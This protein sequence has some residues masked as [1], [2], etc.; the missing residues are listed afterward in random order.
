MDRL[1]RAQAAGGKALRRDV[2]RPGADPLLRRDEPEEEKLLASIARPI[3]LLAKRQPVALAEAVAPRNRYVGV[4]LPYTPLHH[5]LLRHGFRPL[6]MTSGNLSEEPIAIDNDDAFERL[7]GIADFFLIHNR[8]IYLRSDDSVVRRAAG[9]TRFLRR[10]RGYV[11]VP[12]FLQAQAAA[13]PGLRR[14]S[15][16][17]PSASPG[18]TRPS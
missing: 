12:V 17:T 3:V 16:K 14:A 15:S 13:G 4:M 11:P 18:A 6:V 2:L 5:L 7:A 10:S 8:D 1:R 9:A